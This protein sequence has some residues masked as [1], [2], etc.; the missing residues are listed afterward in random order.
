MCTLLRG[1]TNGLVQE[2]EAGEP[3]PAG[4]DYRSVDAEKQLPLISL[5][6][7]APRRLTHPSHT[8]TYRFTLFHLISDSW[9]L[10]LVKLMQIKLIL[11]FFNLLKVMLFIKKTTTKNPKH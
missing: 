11:D 1:V 3:G 10:K 2:C 4:P 9:N 8:H 6:K 7:A 5:A